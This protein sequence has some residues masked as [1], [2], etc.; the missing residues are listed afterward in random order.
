MTK[1]PNPRLKEVTDAEWRSIALRLFDYARYKRRLLPSHVTPEDMACEAIQLAL[2]GDRT[3]DTIQYPDL[4]DFLTGI[5]NSRW[6]NQW[7]KKEHKRTISDESTLEIVTN[8]QAIDEFEKQESSTLGLI[9]DPGSEMD[10][11]LA[12]IEAAAQGDAECESF[13]LAIE[14]GCCSI[15]EVAAMLDWTPSKTY[16]VR[17]KLTE[18]L[19][20]HRATKVATDDAG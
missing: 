3:W 8:Q 13:Y 7:R 12:L 18:R 4:F 14:Y 17:V 19:T 20:T 5:I 6:H 2:T 9:P 1:G 16:K 15:K 11:R 10:K